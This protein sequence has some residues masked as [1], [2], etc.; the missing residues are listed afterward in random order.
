MLKEIRPAIVL[1]VA[2][3]ADHRPRLSAR[4]DRH[5]R[6]DLP[7][8]GARQPDREGRQGHRLRPDRAGVQRATN[9]SMAARRRP[10][11]PIRRFDQDRSGALQCG[12]L[13][14]LQSR[15]DQQGAERPRE[16]GCREA[17]GGKP[18][19]AGAGRSGDHLGQWPRSRY[20]AGSR[21]VP[22]AARCEG[23]QYA[24]RSRPRSS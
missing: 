3:T 18:V 16:G 20:L 15:A 4:H 13:E 10:R 6:R 17:E 7:V 22:G 14:R 19:D 9:I 21:A 5:R 12:Q 11:R 23:A 8:P 2:L 1:L 24:G